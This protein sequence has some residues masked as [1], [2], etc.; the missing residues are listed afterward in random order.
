MIGRTMPTRQLQISLTT[1]T[2]VTTMAKRFVSRSITHLVWEL[3]MWLAWLITMKSLFKMRMVH[4]VSSGEA[5]PPL[6]LTDLPQLSG[7]LGQLWMLA[8]MELSL[9]QLQ[10][11]NSPITCKDLRTMSHGKFSPAKPTQTLGSLVMFGS[12]PNG[13][14]GMDIQ[15]LMDLSQDRQHLSMQMQQI[16]L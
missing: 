16:T 9:T 4:S 1:P 15:D 3:A 11:A 5:P 6:E 13:Q 2:W 12:R 10:R 14:Q 8:Q 7:P